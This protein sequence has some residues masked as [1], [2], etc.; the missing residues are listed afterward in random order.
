VSKAASD[1]R[2]RQKIANAH[3]SAV[4]RELCYLH[5]EGR[6]LFPSQRT[7]ASM[8]VI[9]PRS[10]WAALKLLEQFGVIT[11]QV[12]KNEKGGRVSDAFAI[13]LDADFRLNR[14]TIAAAKKAISKSIPPRKGCEAPSQG[15][16]HNGENNREDLSQEVETS[17]LV[18]GTP[19]EATTYVP[20]LRLIRGGRS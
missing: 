20:Q 2:K 18:L 8:A 9:S 13:S 11:R 15:L 3:M 5:Q 12:R 17:D 4:L 19:R 7:L 6:Q 10:V 16:R 1:W 14:A